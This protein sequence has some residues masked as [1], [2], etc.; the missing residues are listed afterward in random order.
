MT[1]R[2]VPFLA[3]LDEPTL[4]EVMYGMSEHSYPP[5][6]RLFKKGEEA[7]EMHVVISGCVIIFRRIQGLMVPIERLYRGS[8]INSSL[9]LTKDELEYSAFCGTTA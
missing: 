1:L 9:F 4:H 6:H 7:Q 2:R 3:T 8:I 5:N